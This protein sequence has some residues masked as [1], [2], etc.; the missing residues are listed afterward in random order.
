[1]VAESVI[2]SSEWRWVVISCSLLLIVISV[3]FVWAYGVGAPA[4]H[5]TGVLV[6][7]LD[8]ASYQAKMAQG[9]AGGWLFHLPFTPEQH[10]GVFL[11]TVYLALGHLARVLGMQ[12]ILVFHVMRL[13]GA[14]L[15]AVA[16]YRFTADWT[17]NVAQRRIAWGLAMIGAGFG[18]LSLLAGY[19]APDILLLPEAFPLQAAFANPHFPW[20]IAIA[21]TVAH[22]LTQKALVETDSRPALDVETVALAFGTVLLVSMSPFVLVPIGIGYGVLLGWLWRQQRAF[23]RSGFAWGSV[24]LIFGLPVLAYN[25]WAVSAAHPVFQAWMRQNVT[26][27]PP[28]WGYLI[29]F[30]PLLLLAALGLWASRGK[31]GAGDVFLLAWLAAGALLLYAPVGLQRRFAMG[32]IAPLA[33]YAGRGLWR[34]LVP[35]VRRVHPTITV[36]AVFALVIPST[37]LAVVLPMIGSLQ[38][39]AQGG[40]QYYVS[41]GEVEALD[42]LG[43]DTGS[44]GALVLASP[45]LSL[46]LPAH[47]LRVVYGHPFET[48]DAEARLDAVEAYFNGAD[49][50]VIAREGVDYVLVGPR[51]R[52]LQGGGS[53]CAPGMLVFESSDGEVAVYAAS[54]S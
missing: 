34:V 17:D 44:P 2:D 1:M 16:L 28:V 3:P 23:P 7:P 54:G 51:E 43:S 20:A 33:V 47:G 31:L 39:K 5:F 8:G 50:S 52:A 10:Q 6:N 46:F 27:S 40:G 15:M 18:W 19:T 49:C 53:M 32:L 12:S 35:A 25:A 21:L 24:A 22:I 42:W 37:A 38:L 11:Y 9:Y 30:G 36:L 14:V 13:V 4:A 29:A 45:E 26:P 41:R 48:L